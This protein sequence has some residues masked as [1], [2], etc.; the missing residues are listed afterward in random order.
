MT[1]QQ[2]LKISLLPFSLQNMLFIN[3]IINLLS[4]C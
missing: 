4:D 3:A 1:I 2:A